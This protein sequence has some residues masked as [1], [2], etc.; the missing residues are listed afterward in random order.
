M[1][2]AHK[3]LNVGAAMKAYHIVWNCQEK[4]ENVIIHLGDFHDFLAFLKIIRKYVKC[5]GFKDVVYQTNLC[6]PGSLNAVLTGKYYNQSWWVH[7]N[8]SEALE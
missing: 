6:S 1:K 7:E 4:Q 2:Y 3:T 5:S 8:F